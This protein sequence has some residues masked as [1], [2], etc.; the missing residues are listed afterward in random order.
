MICGSVRDLSLATGG[1]HDPQ[2]ESFQQ[3]PCLCVL[4]SGS[5][6]LLSVPRAHACGCLWRCG[7]QWLRSSDRHTASP[8]VCD[9]LY[10]ML[11]F[12]LKDTPRC[13][14]RESIAGGLIHFNDVPSIL[15]GAVEVNSLSSFERGLPYEHYSLPFCQPDSGVA[16]FDA[17][18]N[19]GDILSGLQLYTSPYQFLTN[20]CCKTCC[21]LTCTSTI[22]V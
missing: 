9:G 3:P 10:D 2:I 15:C 18:F 17:S 4:V 6:R 19:P 22:S 20:V 13:C 5:N 14:F 7:L 11:A 16:K 8:M 21:C 1:E 12:M